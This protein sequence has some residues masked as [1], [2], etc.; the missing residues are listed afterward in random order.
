MFRKS[1]RCRSF[2][3]PGGIT[4]FNPDSRNAE[5][6]HGRRARGQGRGEP[7]PSKPAA[8]SSGL[9][10]PGC[11]IL[12]DKGGA[13][14]E[15]LPDVALAPPNIRGEGAKVQSDW[16]FEFL[17][18]P[19]TGQIRPWLKVRMP[20]F[21]FTTDQLNTLTRYFAAMD[22]ARYPFE[23]RVLTLEDRSRLAGAKTFET[24]KCAQCHPTSPE[25][26]SAQGRED[27]GRPRADALGHAY[28]PPLRLDRGLDPSSGKLMPARAADELPEGRRQVRHLASGGRADASV[29]AAQR[30]SSRSGLRAEAK[31]YMSDLT[32]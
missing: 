6:R 15:T 7:V 32:A 1:S 31:A 29:R 21:D 27:P 23:N 11:H 5:R 9:Q 13:I 14:R 12:E 25:P 20:T 22:K 18:A 3:L 16:F 19:K 4:A 24:L 26:A 2:A 17:H 8:A 28:A 30:S 10:L